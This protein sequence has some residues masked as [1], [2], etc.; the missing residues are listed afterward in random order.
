MQ[1]RHYSLF[2]SASKTLNWESLRDDE[3]EDAYFLPY[4]REA[5]L[6]K[7][8]I[9]Q[10]SQNT[11]QV[12]DAC[13]EFLLKK[14]FSIGSGVAA[15]EYQLKKFASLPVI[16][17][18]Y[19][20][21]IRRIKEFNVFDDAIQLDAFKDAFPVDKDTLVLFPRID[22]EFE[23]KQLELIFKKCFEAGVRHIWFIPAELLTMHIIA[24]EFKIALLS[25]LR[26]KPRVFCGYARSKSAFE[27]IWGKYY[28]I[29][30][31]IDNEKTTYL[32]QSVR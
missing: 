23:N 17:S 22:T 18:D 10:P 29:V 5:Y 21:S 16:V 3:S 7:V 26:R 19:T 30:R 31:V 14:I 20:D 27:K 25:I 2:N 9:E 11:Q 4:T 12:V 8:D 6:K 24:A 15:Q 13:K 32:L 28:R 1:I